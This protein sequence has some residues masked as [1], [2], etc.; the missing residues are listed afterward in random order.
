M[1]A[2]RMNQGNVNQ[3]PIIEKEPNTDAAR[4]FDQLK[5]FDEPL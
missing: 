4:F 2:M 1:D 3:C 5:D